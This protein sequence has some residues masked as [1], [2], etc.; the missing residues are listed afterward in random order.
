MYLVVG[1]LK[2]GWTFKESIEFYNHWTY[3]STSGAFVYN[4]WFAG[5]LHMFNFNN[6]IQF[7]G[8]LVYYG[9]IKQCLMN[10]KKDELVV[11]DQKANEATKQINEQMASIKTKN[12]R[13]LRHTITAV[14]KKK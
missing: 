7:F 1:L 13:M 4:G 12:H 3:D 9:L 6:E 10:K 8:T 14:M 5:V 2:I 11:D